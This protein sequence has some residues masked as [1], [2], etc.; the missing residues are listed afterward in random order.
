M[1]G[2][3]VDGDA[4]AD[5]ELT[6]RTSAYAFGQKDVWRLIWICP[7]EPLGTVWIM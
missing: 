4:Q 5:F 2:E 3:V 7:F 1:R 6:D